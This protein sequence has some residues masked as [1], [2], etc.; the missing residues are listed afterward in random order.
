MQSGQHLP[1]PAGRLRASRSSPAARS[2]RSAWPSTRG[3]LYTADCHSKPITQLIPGAYY[4][5]FGKPHDGLGFA[6]HVTR[7]DHGS[8]G[9]C[10]LVVVRRRPVPEGVPRHACS[11]ATW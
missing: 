11:S 9:L 1:L 2:T 5:S 8:T 10:G 6:P 4:D 7:H 3:N